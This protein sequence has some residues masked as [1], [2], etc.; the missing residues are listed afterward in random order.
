MDLYGTNHDPS[1]W[2]APERFDPERFRT[3]GTDAFDLL[4]HGGGSAAD[5]HRCPGEGITQAL[6]MTAANLLA[7]SMHYEVPQQDL[8]IDLTY[9]PARPRSGFVL[10]NV[11]PA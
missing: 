6:L 8:R 7:T 9:I 11:R 5:G 4:S 2:H 3:E 10:R 1:R